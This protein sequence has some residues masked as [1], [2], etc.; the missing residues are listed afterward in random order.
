MIIPHRYNVR[1]Q[2]MEQ[3]D[4]IAL[5]KENRDSATVT[6]R[7]AID[8]VLS[9]P[10]EVM[11]M[12]IHELADAS[13]V[14]SSTISRM[15]RHLGLSGYRQFQRSLVFEL[16]RRRDSERT[17]IGDISPKDSV[18]QTILKVTRKNMESL[19]I[20]EKLNDVEAIET[21]VAM[22]SDSET[23]NLFGMGSSLLSARDLYYKLIRANVRCNINDDWHAQLVNATNMGEG[24]LAIAFSYSG[25]THEVI[26]CSRRA[27]KR[28][29]RLIA[30]TRA[31]HDSE[32]VRL[33]DQTLYVASTESIFRS[34]ASASR[35]SQLDIVDILFTA[36]VNRNYERCSEWFERNYIE[37]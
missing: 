5:L 9:H 28:G 4:V 8:Y 21:C 10:E 35:I 30:I 24:D 18:R 33:A 36:Y 17:S 26:S 25:L 1:G 11:G 13:F 14:S 32:L 12:S 37:R 19:A 31:G 6:E 23:I 29:A 27:K 22:M 34:S 3:R 20:T 15:C 16:A 2:A 7:N